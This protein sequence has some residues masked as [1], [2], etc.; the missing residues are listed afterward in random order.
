MFLAFKSEGQSLGDL[1]R[2]T[3]STAESWDMEDPQRDLNLNP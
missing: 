1:G 3:Q 2:L